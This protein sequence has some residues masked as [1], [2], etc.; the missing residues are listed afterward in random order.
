MKI[1]NNK[2]LIKHETQSK[3]IFFKLTFLSKSL[4]REIKDTK[5]TFKLLYRKTKLTT[6]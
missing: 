2:L 6:P 1:N 5:E 4:N 3:V